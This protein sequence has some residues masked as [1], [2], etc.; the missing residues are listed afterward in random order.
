M[1]SASV[2]KLTP[3]N[4]SYINSGEQWVNSIKI[5]SKV[6]MKSIMDTIIRVEIYVLPLKMIWYNIVKQSLVV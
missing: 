4:F 5:L 3:L 1:L 6:Y 2:N